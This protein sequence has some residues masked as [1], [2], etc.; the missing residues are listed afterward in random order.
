M[1][2]RCTL[3][4]IA[5]C[6]GF[7]PVMGQ[8]EPKNAPASC[9]ATKDLVNTDLFGAWTLELQGAP[10]SIRLT[11]QRNPEFTESL[12]GSFQ[13]GNARHQIFGDIEEGAL[14]LEESNNGKDIIALWKGRVQEGSCGQAIT[15]Q[16][17]LT[18][19]GDAQA[20]V[21]RRSGW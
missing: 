16:R 18:S 7:M 9:L 12:A 1:Q 14:D 6:A 17:R 2:F 21:L 8:N 15:G 13:L 5:L 4:F 3:I 20:F 10:A 19:T 11:M